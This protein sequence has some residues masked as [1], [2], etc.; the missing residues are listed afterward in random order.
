MRILMLTRVMSAHGSGGM[1]QHAENI[2]K[3]LNQN[4]EITVITTAHPQ[5][6]EEEIRRNVRI[7]Y[8]RGTIH[9]KYYGGWWKRS[10]IKMER[11][12][13]KEKFDLLLSESIAAGGYY[14]FGLDRKYKIPGLAFIHGTFVKEIKTVFER[15]WNLKLPFSL[16]YK[17]YIY[18]SID[19]KFYPRVSG[20]IAVSREIKEYL[21]KKYPEKQIFLIYNGVD[22]DLFSLRRKNLDLLSQLKLSPSDKILLCVGRLLKEKGIDEVLNI[23]PGLI[24]ELP[25]VK[26]IWAGEGEYESRARK[27]IEKMELK[28]KVILLGRV[29]QKILPDIYNL[30][31]IFLFPSRREEGLPLVLLEA[32]SCGVP[33]IGRR[34][35]CIEEVVEEGKVGFLY[36]PQNLVELKEKI[37]NLLLSPLHVLERMKLEAR[38]LAVEKFSL[39]RMGGETEKVIRKFV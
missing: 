5:G 25:R 33:V 21:V 1:Q 10:R 37:R 26:L 27:K 28:D 3:W 38:K 17:L 32:L 13:E 11:L 22:T 36:S 7:I 4:S 31:D 15:G 18:Q 29:D 20:I 35:G 12:L 9:G 2:I 14:S 16:L 23:M 19:K 6:K 8:L 30:A 24:R 34:S 39:Y